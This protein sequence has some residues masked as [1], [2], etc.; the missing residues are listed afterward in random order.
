[1]AALDKQEGVVLLPIGAVEQH[2]PHL[3][4]LTDTIIVTGLL[5]A[6]LAQLPAEVRAWALPPLSYGKSTEHLK[7]PGTISLSAQTLGAVLHDLAASLQRA[8]FR[9]LA[10]VNGHGGNNA[11]LDM[12]ARDIRAATGLLCFCIHAGAFTD[13]PFDITPEEDRY[14]LHAG[15]LETSLM[16]A[17]APELVR[18]ELA[19]RHFPAFPETGTRLYF[20]GQASAA[21]LAHDWSPSGAFGDATLATAE[22][23]QALVERGIQ[24]LTQLIAAIS[25]FE[26]PDARA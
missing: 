17:L 9:R 15:E 24:H 8:G 13:P 26:I 1:V 20:V 3:P 16:L 6:A 2:G 11:L 10:F 14:G 23:G 12:T 21:W 19:P 22:K 5:G 18:M 4:L 25:R 7:F